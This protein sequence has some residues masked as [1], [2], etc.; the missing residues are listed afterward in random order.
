MIKSHYVAYIEHFETDLDL[1][2]FLME[3]L[4]V[5]QDLLR[6]GVYPPDWNEMLMLQNRYICLNIN[7][8]FLIICSYECYLFNM[9][10]ES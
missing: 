6:K 1:M 3:I 5:F 4:M 2:D 9:P 10:L 7:L 8:N